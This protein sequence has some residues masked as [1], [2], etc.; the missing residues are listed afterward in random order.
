[1]KLIN[2][3]QSDLLLVGQKLRVP[4]DYEVAPGDTLWKLS[5]SFTST[6][7]LI[8]TANGLTSDVIYV[9]QKLEIQPKKLRMQ[10]QFIL[11]NRDEFKDWIFNQKFTRRVGKVQQ[12]HTYQ[13]SYKQFNGSNHFSLMQGMKE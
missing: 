13:P 1:M 7:Q 2:G 9:G 8:K 3:L 10:G 4:I 11:M 5:Q 12:H 6:V